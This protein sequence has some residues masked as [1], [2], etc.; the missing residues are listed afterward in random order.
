MS[1]AYVCAFHCWRVFFVLQKQSFRNGRKQGGSNLI[2]AENTQRR[3][4]FSSVLTLCLRI[5]NAH[6]EF[7]SKNNWAS[8]T[9][10]KLGPQPILPNTS[11]PSNKHKKL[12][13]LCYA[14]LNWEFFGRAERST[15]LIRKKEKSSLGY[16]WSECLDFR[17]SPSP[18]Q[19]LIRYKCRKVNL[20]LISLNL[21]QTRSN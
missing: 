16:C 3:R 1:A 4:K 20:I 5:S 9:Q 14:K 6:N 15:Q 12:L 18:G 8:T 17:V 11:F 2:Y 13:P 7:G 19:P 10:S 21:S